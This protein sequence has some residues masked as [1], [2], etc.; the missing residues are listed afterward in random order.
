M[1]TKLLPLALLVACIDPDQIQEDVDKAVDEAV[2]KSLAGCERIFDSRTPIL[3]AQVVAAVLPVCSEISGEL[4][5]LSDEIR[6]TPRLTA[7]YLLLELGCIP[8]DEGAW[9]C[10]GLSICKNGE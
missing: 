1:I 9:D 6:L 7:N 8:T 4:G 5:S 2:N 3:V 10:R